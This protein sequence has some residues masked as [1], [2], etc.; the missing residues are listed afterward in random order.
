VEVRGPKLNLNDDL[1]TLESFFRAARIPFGVVLWSGYDPE[2]SDRSYYT[3]VMRWAARVHAAIGAPD[4]TIF[5][6]WVRR[7]SVKCVAGVH[8]GP[9]NR[10]MCSPADCGKASVPINLPDGDPAIFSHTRLIN[11]ALAILKR[12]TER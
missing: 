5:Q 1:Q 10:W 6:S 7:S 9:S 4:Q 11:D 2:S 12:P 3:H 8:C